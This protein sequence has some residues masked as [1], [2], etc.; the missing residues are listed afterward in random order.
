MN[1]SLGSLVA[2]LGADA[3]TR[4]LYVPRDLTCQGHDDGKRHGAATVGEHLDG[5]SP[6][7]PHIY[8]QTVGSALTANPLGS[9]VKVI[10]AWAA[11]RLAHLGPLTQALAG[12]GSK[13][14]P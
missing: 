6:G 2:R 11:C 10:L 9:Q 3:A 14:R 8:C 12:S 1:N 7:R 13:R 5:V 4:A